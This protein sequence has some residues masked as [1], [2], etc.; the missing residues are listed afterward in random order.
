MNKVYDNDVKRY[1]RG[2][3]TFEEMK[4]RYPNIHPTDLK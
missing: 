4:E 2:E 3:L 1:K